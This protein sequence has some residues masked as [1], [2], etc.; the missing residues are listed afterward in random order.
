MNFRKQRIV[1]EQKTVDVETQNTF[2]AYAKQ[3]ILLK[4]DMDKFVVDHAIPIQDNITLPLINGTNYNNNNTNANNNSPLS[5]ANQ[6]ILLPIF[7]GYNL[8]MRMPLLL[9]KHKEDILSRVILLASGIPF[10]QLQSFLTLPRPTNSLIEASAVSHVN[11]VALGSLYLLGGIKREG[12]VSLAQAMINLTVIL[13]HLATS[14]AYRRQLAFMMEL[15]NSD[16][17]DESDD[18]DEDNDSDEDSEGDS[19]GPVQII[20]KHE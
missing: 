17:E 1:D 10:L 11:T 5:P 12:R 13:P 8:F 15:S 20:N 3:A 14:I 18:G 4:R 19:S 9:V 2:K 7:T 16:D 6:Q